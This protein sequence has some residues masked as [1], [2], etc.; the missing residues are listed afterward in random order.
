MPW[1][2]QGKDRVGKG[3]K[4]WEWDKGVGWGTLGEVWWDKGVGLDRE[5]EW[6]SLGEVW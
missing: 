2:G 6:G 4:G 3:G 1:W 5:G